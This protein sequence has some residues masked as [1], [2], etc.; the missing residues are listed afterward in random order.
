MAWTRHPPPAVPAEIADEF[1]AHSVVATTDP[2]LMFAPSRSWKDLARYADMKSIDEAP[3]EINSA[4]RERMESIAR[5]LLPEYW[6][7]PAGDAVVVLRHGTAILVPH[8]PT[9]PKF[10]GFAPAKARVGSVLHRLPPH[11]FTDGKVGAAAQ[12]VRA[13]RSYDLYRTEHPEEMKYVNTAL[14]W[15]NNIGYPNAGMQDSDANVV[16]LWRRDG[17]PGFFE[18]AALVECA[19]FA[20]TAVG[21]V[22]T[23][24][25]PVDKPPVHQGYMKEFADAGRNAFRN[26]FL[27]P[28]VLGCF[29]IGGRPPSVAEASS[30][31]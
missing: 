4:N 6:R 30:H 7:A 12:L 8:K 5:T 20:G 31:E 24:P 3:D 29:L 18:W 21:V 16:A 22:V 11:R 19:C 2:S 1:V 27:G 17:K 13:E 14:V 9:G 10:G 28:Q 23:A 15:L 25:L 26:E